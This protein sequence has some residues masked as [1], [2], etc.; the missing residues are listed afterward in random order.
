MEKSD[1]QKMFPC[2]ARIERDDTSRPDSAAWI[3]S[4]QAVG[5]QL[6]PL[7]LN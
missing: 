4:L 6:P 7:K 1:Q 2:P 5:R 3:S